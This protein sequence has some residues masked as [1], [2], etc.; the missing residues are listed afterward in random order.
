MVM[1]VKYTHD[2]MREV[3]RTSV[4]ISEVLLKLGLRLAGGN[5]AHVR[6]RIAEYGIDTWHFLGQRANSGLR[7]RGPRR[8]NAQELLW[9]G[10]ANNHRFVPVA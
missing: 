4:S 7:H 3:V 8:V 6:R 2:R 1:R 5:H 9:S 10:A